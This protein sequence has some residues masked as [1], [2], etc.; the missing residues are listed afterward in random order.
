MSDPRVSRRR[1]LKLGAVAAALPLVH[2]RTAGAAG[3]LS[4]FFW[5]HWVPA[6][7]DI[8]RKQVAAWADKNKVDVQ[9]DF[10]TSLGSKDVLTINAEAQARSGHDAV[11]IGNWN[12]QNQADNL[13]PMNDVVGRLT[14]QYGPVNRVGQYL[15]QSK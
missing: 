1:A 13:E 15:G 4:I 9:I 11:H 10:I 5:D 8:M 14:A 3:K 2:I 6:G 7:N 12:V